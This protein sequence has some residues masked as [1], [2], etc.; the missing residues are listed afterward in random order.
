MCDDFGM[1]Q[2]RFRLLED[3]DL[4][5]MHRWLNDP[6]VV[7]WWE[8][9]DVSWDGVVDD[10]AIENQGPEEHWIALIDDEPIGWI[11]CGEISN[12]PDE[13]EDWIELGATPDCAGIDYL[14]GEAAQRGNG[15]GSA[16]IAAFVEQVVFGLHAHWNQVGADPL[17][18]NTASWRA[19]EKAGFTAAGLVPD[20]DD[21]VLTSKVMLRNRP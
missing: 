6:E 9:D 1:V 2:I 19:L 14:I 21:P 10:Y 8:G 5:L 11:Q 12:W 16:M 15:L 4:P 17:E 7:R 18:A 20:G 3:A 13:S